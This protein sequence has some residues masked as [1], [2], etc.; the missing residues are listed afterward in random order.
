M[1]EQARSRAASVTATFAF[2]VV[3]SRSADLTISSSLEH[4]SSIAVL[5]SE[6]SA[7]LNG[8]RTASR[9]VCDSAARRT[10]TLIRRNSSV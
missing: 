2:P 8:R 1:D 9:A 10:P 6:A 7:S 5:M 4:A 3:T